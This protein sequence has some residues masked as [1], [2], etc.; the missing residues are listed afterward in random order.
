MTKRDVIKFL[1]RKQQEKTNDITAQYNAEREQYVQSIY[2][3][4][5]LPELA[6]KIQP[7]LDKAYRLLENWKEK[8]KNREGLSIQTY[9]FSLA[10]QLISCTSSENAT[11]KKLTNDDMKLETKEMGLLH[12]AFLDER[13]CVNATFNTVIQSV[14]QMKSAKQAAIYLRELGF[15]LSELENP[16]EQ[17]Q[18]ALM[19]PVDTQF[20]FVKDAA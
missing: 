14:Q 18:T 3:A 1:E 19:V 16:S 8:H 17:A 5:Q 6:S 10:G 15:D 13:N 7:L 2:S 20:L 11:Y 4:M 12:R 9:Y